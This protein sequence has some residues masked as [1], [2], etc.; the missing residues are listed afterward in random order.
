MTPKAREFVLAAE[1]RLLD[2]AV[3]RDR[4]SVEALLHPS[5]REIGQSGRLWDREA[6][7][8][9]L[10]EESGDDFHGAVDMSEIELQTLCD[11]TFLLTY[12][13][14]VED[15]WTRRSSI[16]LLTVHRARLIFHQGT[17]EPSVSG[18]GASEVS[19][20]ETT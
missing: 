4:S 19:V 18:I 13:L 14:R 17:K 11:S 3:R 10:A 16:W 2:P 15:R 7:I 1:R 5:F 8:A 12:R 9:A 20:D 6:T